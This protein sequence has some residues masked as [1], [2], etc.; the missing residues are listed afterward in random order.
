MPL[1]KPGEFAK[2]L[3]AMSFIKIG[4]LKTEGVQIGLL[5]TPLPRFRFKACQQTMPVTA[6]RS[7]SLTHNRSTYS[8]PQ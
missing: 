1:R 5:C 8:Q 7:S 2:N 4:R 3:V 6:P